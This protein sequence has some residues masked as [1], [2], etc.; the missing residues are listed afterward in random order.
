MTPTTL[1]R[2]AAVA[3]ALA[4]LAA[5]P[6]APASAETSCW[7]E[8]RVTTVW[9]DPTSQAARFLGEFTV[10]NGD[11][12]LTGW[13]VTAKWLGINQIDQAYNA[14]MSGAPSTYTFTDAG[15]NGWLSPGA[16]TTF[17]V[18]GTRPSIYSS[19]MPSLR[20]CTPA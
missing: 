16:T 19:A 14:S 8:Y 9:T 15:W 1:R 6:A 18:F 20:R 4:V 10:H 2:A 12:P 13:T 5:L 17:G 11:T 3:G 7:I